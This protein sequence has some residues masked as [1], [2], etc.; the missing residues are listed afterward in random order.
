[1]AGTR[2]ATSRGAEPARLG[3]AL[4]KATFPDAQIDY[5]V[6]GLSCEFH[7]PLSDDADSENM[8]AANSRFQDL[9]PDALRDTSR[10]TPEPPSA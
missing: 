5:A 9:A 7:L 3:T 8:L 1:M 2:R 4:V 10:Q 6:K